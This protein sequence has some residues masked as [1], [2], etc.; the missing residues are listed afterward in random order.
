MNKSM[1]HLSTIMMTDL[2]R[3]GAE[4]I[5]VKNVIPL[6]P[7]NQKDDQYDDA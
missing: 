4:L 2:H 5:R 1:K 3:R 7:L 6:H